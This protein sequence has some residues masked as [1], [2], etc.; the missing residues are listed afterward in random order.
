MTT[1]LQRRPGTTKIVDLVFSPPEACTVN[2]AVHR[3]QDVEPMYRAL[4][5]ANPELPSWSKVEG[6]LRRQWDEVTG[7]KGGGAIAA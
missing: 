1:H 5:V 2:Y 3:W 4:L 7:N 6:E